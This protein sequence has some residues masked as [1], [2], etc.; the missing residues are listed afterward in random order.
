MKAHLKFAIE[1]SVLCDFIVLFETR[2]TEAIS[3]PLKIIPNM[4]DKK[5]S[6]SIMKG[7]L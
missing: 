2:E 5:L 6:G 1:Q 4:N 7:A 3:L